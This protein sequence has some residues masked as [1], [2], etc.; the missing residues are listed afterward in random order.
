MLRRVL[1]TDVAA[2]TEHC[3]RKLRA[4]R[5]LC[6]ARFG[7]R[8]ELPRRVGDAVGMSHG[9]HRAWHVVTIVTEA[10]GRPRAAAELERH[11]YALGASAHLHRLAHATALLSKRGYVVVSDKA[12]RAATSL[13]G[14]KNIT[15]TAV[16]TEHMC[17]AQ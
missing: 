14:A 12:F 15:Q 3:V 4:E 16:A 13:E 10:H 1:A 2:V 11:I 6:H 8:A 9:E 5:G 17:T 7:I